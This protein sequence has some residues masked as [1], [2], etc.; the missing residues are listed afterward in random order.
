MENYN[1]SQMTHNQLILSNGQVHK[2]NIYNPFTN[3]VPS[4]YSGRNKV[5]IGGSGTGWADRPD[6][7]RTSLSK[8]GAE[9]PI[10]EP[11]VLA[12][13]A[14]IYMGLKKS[15]L[16]GMLLFVASMPIHAQVTDLTISTARSGRTVTIN[17]TIASVP[18]ANASV[19][20]GL[21]YDA[22][23]TNAVDGIRFSA[24]PLTG[25]NAVG[26]TAPTIAGTY[27][28]KTAISAAY[29][30]GGLVDSE[31]ITPI[32]IYPA[33][34]DIV[35]LRDAQDAAERVDVTDTESQAYGVMRFRKTAV[36]DEAVS[37]YERYNYFISFPFD[38]KVG[39]IYGI[40]S[41]GTDWRILYYDG[42]GRAQEG[43][44]AERTD[45]WVMFGDTED[46]L[47]A[48]EGYLLQLNTYSMDADNEAIWTNGADIASLFFPALTTMSAVE[49]TNV[50]IPALGS[51]YVCTID[52]S[53][54]LGDDNADRRAKDSYWRC[55]G[56]PSF[57]S[58]TGVEGLE[59]FYEWNKGNNSLIA[60]SSEGYTFLPTH[61]YLVQEGESFTWLNTT[62]PTSVAAPRRDAASQ[63][64]KL[65]IWQGEELQDQTFVRQTDEEDVTGGFDFGHDLSKEL[66]AGRTNVYTMVGHERVA[67]NML[68]ETVGTVPVGIVIAQ[69]GEYRLTLTEGAWLV[70]QQTGV[71]TQ[72]DTVYLDTG[73]Y[74][75]RFVVEIASPISTGIQQSVVSDQFSDI[76]KVLIDGILYIEKDGKRYTIY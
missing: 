1:E 34:A 64:W 61:A 19:C 12:L 75:G 56:V 17:P 36:N 3:E 39:D 6:V 9:V 53:A 22:A 41:V 46:V 14:L 57:S 35:L 21:Y 50:T 4:E 37:A 65:A 31:V 69:S 63:E 62:V 13:F 29:V 51:E 27:Y 42:I 43:F 73:T 68:P 28:L 76:R 58:P 25:V 16:A 66:N 45:N 33:D 32:A 26:F 67:A 24:A 44:F 11:Y 2:G 30:C 10:G 71:R 5:A 74:E 72:D 59:Y 40:G 54:T 60:Q 47:H 70:D 23:C 38:V 7:G 15:V 52:L 55:V 18:Y 20:W 49:T 8:T 48:G